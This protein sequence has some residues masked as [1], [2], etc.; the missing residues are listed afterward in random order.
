MN[1]RKPE[2][3]NSVE[4]LRVKIP[5][6]TNVPIVNFEV[7]DIK[8][9][10]QLILDAGRCFAH[11]KEFQDYCYGQGWDLRK[12]VKP[13]LTFEK[14]WNQKKEIAPGYILGKY[15]ADAQKL[16]QFIYKMILHLKEVP[17]ATAEGYR[18]KLIAYNKMINDTIKNCQR[19]I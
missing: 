18:V 3:M 8:E 10:A 7:M 13:L 9:L 6:K 17:T 16:Y 14:C 15:V 5:V 1:H 19:R 4:L 12:W 11:N 2:L